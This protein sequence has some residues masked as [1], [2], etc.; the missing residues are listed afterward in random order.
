VA[1]GAPVRHVVLEDAALR[2]ELLSLGARLHDVRLAGVDHPL[3]VGCPGIAAY[4]GPLAYFG[5]I[6]GPV[7]NRI[8]GGAA[9]ID[10][11]T[12][13]FE[14]NEGGRT[15][16]HSGAAGTH[17]RNWQIAEAAATAVTFTLAL[18]D[19][20]GGFPGNRRL[21][22]RY[23]LAREGTLELEI[24]AETDAPT[25]INL[26]SHAFWRLGPGP[27]LAGHRLRVAAEHYLPTDATAL[28]TGAV[29]EVTGTA[30]DF[31]SPRP[32]GPGSAPRLDHN[33]CL[34]QG[35]RAPAEVLTLWGPGGLR[36]D[37]ATSE[38][39]VQIF[40]AAPLRAQAGL[41]CHAG[42]PVGAWCGLAIEPQ[43]WPDAPN[44]PAFPSVRLDPGDRYHQI[45]RFALQRDDP[46]HARRPSR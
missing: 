9:E 17:A 7:A 11:R 46:A 30:F 3:V 10:G 23:A 40:D 31:R 41:R 32:V 12:H 44:R 2:V 45:T 42:H 6:V 18:A 20:D 38:P 4:A 27:D 15:T 5:A 22:A 16:L 1:E 36:L 19:G 29:E 25:W 43:G 28:V 39:G 14:R 24:T 26:A 13:R 21:A 34:S 33:F 35:R 8:A 37:M